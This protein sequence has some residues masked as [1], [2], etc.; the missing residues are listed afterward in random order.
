MRLVPPEELAPLST[1]VPAADKFIHVDLAT[2]MVT[3]F[4]GNQM[5]FSSRCSSGQKGTD[6]PSG[7]FSTYHKG[8]SIH[9]TNDQGDAVIKNVYNLAGVPWCSFFTG[10]GHAFH[11]T[12][13]HNDYGRPRSH[14]CVNLP[15]LNAKWIYLWTNPV[16]PPEEDYLHL[17]GQGTRVQIV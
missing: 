11:G 17:P 3:A 9:M 4:E 6:T 13:W 12:Y 5:V 15:S 14:G 10:A 2:Q 7:D 1:N 16:V 8:P